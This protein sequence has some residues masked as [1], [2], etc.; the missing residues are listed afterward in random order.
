MRISDLFLG[1]M[2]RRNRLSSESAVPK[3]NL[4]PPGNTPDRKA[5]DRRITGRSF[6]GLTV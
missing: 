2:L 3:D 5:L 4:V 1:D 6:A